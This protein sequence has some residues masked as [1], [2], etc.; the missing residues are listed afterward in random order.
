MRKVYISDHEQQNYRS[1]CTFV[2][3]ININIQNFKFLAN[4][5]SYRFCARSEFS[6]EEAQHLL[7]CAHV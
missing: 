2:V 1:A 3:V 5:Y 6:C 4:L 7:L